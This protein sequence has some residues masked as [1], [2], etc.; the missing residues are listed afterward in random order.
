VRANR[1]KFI[2][3][4][5]STPRSSSGVWSQM[6]MLILA[7]LVAGS[8]PVF[9]MA[10]S[11]NGAPG[12]DPKAMVM[13]TVAQ[14]IHVLS[15]H[16]MSHEA[17]RQRL[18]RVVAGHFDFADMARSSLGY[19]WRQ[20]T[21]DQQQRFVRLFTAFI[22]DAYL[23]KLEEYSGQKIKFLGEAS[24]GPGESQVSTLVVQPNEE[25]P[26]HLDYQAVRRQLEGL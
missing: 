2:G 11:A 6:G 23:N 12:G 8:T 26:I 19:H 17:R 4:N 18:I 15:D 14:A 7:L 3:R 20:L 21:P 10:T 16:H 25:E 13:G 22:E 5:L 1:L 9:A 24:N